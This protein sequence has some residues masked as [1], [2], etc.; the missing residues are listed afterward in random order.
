[1]RRLSL[2]VWAGFIMLPGAGLAVELEAP[3]E[4]V[5]G[6]SIEVGWTGTPQAQDYTIRLLD[7][8]LSEKSISLGAGQELAVE[9]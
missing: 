1:M 4:V 2:V 9:F 8:A 3:A 5:A 7:G 6:S